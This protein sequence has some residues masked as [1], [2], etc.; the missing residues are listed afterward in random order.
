MKYKLPRI[1]SVRCAAAALLLA[2]VASLQAADI[3][4]LSTGALND[5]AGWSG[6]VL[7]SAT[8]DNG[9]FD[10]STVPTAA[11]NSFG[12]SSFSILGIKVTNIAG[13]LTNTATTTYVYIGGG[14]D[15]SAAAADVNITQTIRSSGPSAGASY[16]LIV[17]PGR[18]LTLNNQTFSR[19]AYTMP[20]NGGGTIL[21]NGLTDGGG[22]NRV[23]YDVTG[24]GTTIGGTGTWEPSNTSGG[25]GV[26]M[27]AGT[28]VAPGANGVGTTTFNGA[29]SGQAILTMLS[30]ADFQ[31][32][33]GTGGTFATPSANSDKLS[34]LSMAAGDVVFNG[35]T[36]NFLGGGSAGVFK[37]FDT[38]LDA[39]TWSGLMLSGQQIVGGLIISNLASGLT[40]TLI[41]GDGTTGDLGDI[42]LVV[43]APALPTLTWAVGD[44]NWDINTSSNWND[45]SGLAAY[46][47]IA[48]TGNN[49]IFNDTASGTSPILV[50]LDTNVAP[51]SFT[52]DNSSLDYVIS[53]A[54]SIGGG[55]ALEKLG[56]G[57]LTLNTSNAFTGGVIVGGGT[58]YANDP[59][60]AALGTGP[61]IITN[62][63]ILSL[64][65]GNTTDNGTVAYFSNPLSV[66]AG[67]TGA[68][69]TSP[70]SRTG[71]SGSASTFTPTVTGSGT[72]NLQ[73]NYVGYIGGDWSGFAGQL[74]VTP[75][76]ASE[77]FQIASGGAVASG[78]PNARINL[79]AGVTM[80]QVLNPPNT[81]D[82][83]TIQ[84]IGELTGD[85]ASIL[86]GN[87]V[88]G[89]FVNWTV[90][91]L[92]TDA[93]FDGTIQDGSGATKITK[94]GTGVWTLTGACYHTGATVVSNGTLVVNGTINNSTVTNFAGTTLAGTGTIS[95]PVYLEAGSTLAT[96]VGGY[97]GMTFNSALTFDGATNLVDI[98]TTNS[99]LIVAS[100]GLYLNSGTV[101]LNIA[102]TLTNGTYKLMGGAVYGGSVANLVLTGFSQPG[103]SATLSYDSI[104]GEIDLVV[105]PLGAANLTWVGDGINNYW[106]VGTSTDWNNGASSVAFANGDD[107]TFN[108]TSANT[109]VRL[110][111]VVSPGY[112]T[113]NN[114]AN[115]YTFAGTGKITGAA[116][117]IKS[118]SSM[119]TILTPNGNSGG[120]LI[121]NGTV[122]VGNG[123][124]T[125]DIGTGNV[126]NNGA[127]VFNQPDA[128]S[129]DGVISGSGGLTQQGS[130]T[131]TLSAD[132]IYT[133]PTTIGSG[134]T[135]QVGNSGATGSLGSGAITND[136]TLIINRSGSLTLGGIKTGPSNG[137]ALMKN[138]NST[139]TLNAGNTYINNTT[140]NN[141]TVKLGA[142]EVIPS[143]ATVSSSAGWLI[144]D[145]GASAA[146]VLDL[147]GFNQTVNALSGNGNTVNGVITNSGTAAVTNTLTIL[148]SAGTT[149]N[150]LIA[151]NTTGSKTMLVLRGANELRM[152]GVS[153]Y[154]GGTEVGDTATL[155]VGPGAA[156]GSGF[157]VMSNSTT[158]KMYNNGSTLAY[159]N[160]NLLIA[161]NATATLDSSSL[162]NGFSG[163]IYGGATAT[164]MMGVTAGIGFSPKNLEQWQPFL[165][166]VVIPSGARIRFSASSQIANGGDNA[167]FDLQANGTINSKSSGTITLGSLQGSGVI[168]G[169][170]TAGNTATYIIGSKNLSSTFSGTINTGTGMNAVTKTGT[171]TLTLDGTLSYVGATTVN[172]GVLA[173]ASV[174]N[175]NTSLD[176]STS[177]TIMSNAVLDVSARGDSALNLGNSVAQTLNGYGTI[178]GSLNEAS[179]ST[180]NVG[181]GTLTVTNAATLNGAITMQLNRTNAVTHSELAAASFSIN[182]PLTVNNIGP[183]LQG[184]DTFQLF[185]T[186]VAGFTVTN[187]PALTGN[188]YWTNN[189]AVDGSIA[190]INPINTNSPVMAVNYSGGVL[191]LAW[192]TNAGWTLQV[193][194]NN[195]S[196]GLGTNWVD[197]PGSTAITSTNI[198]VDPAKPTVFYRLKY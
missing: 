43:T 180:I 51:A 39:T 80:I 46:Q 96:G 12:G 195:L 25:Y 131:L 189:L 103:Q 152:N 154:G 42:Y 168:D 75:R 66:P 192:P 6:G 71:S 61:V 65:R 177:I 114:S 55:S 107:V 170:E 197:V 129:V 70:R 74:N 188:L 102:D 121:N 73:V 147:N 161:D 165:G 76:T 68:L 31:F 50:A 184:G 173:I 160:C 99:D 52:A 34:F 134:A 24:A 2:S 35:N 187:L 172:G 138:G 143:A 176:S 174:S 162:A 119:L 120:T 112:V 1:N 182:G 101:A 48:G 193:Q 151:D 40:G 92:N 198:T 116:G 69:W 171:G 164:N 149:F 94:V 90:G 87:P 28:H 126:T 156:L 194:T 62:G 20:I 10:S 135:L 142:A 137:G 191:S 108:D 144:L 181:L 64:Y 81:G 57:A 186:G 100:G 183:A 47:E 33:L 59:T 9:V 77:S 23:A 8:L 79:A 110:N 58:V 128:R 148:G 53:G 130:S 11:G 169:T 82:L 104:N 78:F 21:V 63:A 115:D 178:R 89:R 136:G 30:G 86:S 150:G 17:A 139:I 72:L 95:G 49:V 155:S 13:P 7:P 19:N 41:L 15:M 159:P 36:I 32:Q 54:G 67:Q 111:D 117:L 5:P 157:V 163:Q 109:Y 127:L 113:V 98:S 153:T 26:R 185:S 29:H 22:V 38:D 105:A 140:I 18:T 97:G 56:T 37:L 3:L 133:G 145:G 93:T 122:Q 106:D 146:G 44:G 123:S 125:G 27:G 124:I 85:P 83:T 60:G 167:T 196:A 158:F 132:N 84:P 166:T 45:G 16:S 4:K 179:S 14:V 118:G 91:G 141:G 175:P 88:S 190:V